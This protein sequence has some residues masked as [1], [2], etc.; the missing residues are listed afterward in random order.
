[1]MYERNARCVQKLRGRVVSN[2]MK[3]GNLYSQLRCDRSIARIEQG[4]CTCQTVVRDGSLC[5][6]LHEVLMVLWRGLCSEK[7]SVPRMKLHQPYGNARQ[8]TCCASNATWP[9]TRDLA[10][11]L[12][13]TAGY[14]RL[15]AGHLLARPDHVTFAG[16]PG[17]RWMA[18]IHRWPQTDRFAPK[19]DSPTSDNAETN[20]WSATTNHSAPPPTTESAISEP[21]GVGVLAAAFWRQPVGWQQREA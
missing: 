17:H 18:R 2:R 8:L 10:A 14:K 3:I 15:G 6:L 5:W 16:H 11:L 1:M 7:F 20:D 4:Y 12:C 21:G 9:M 13:T 19:N